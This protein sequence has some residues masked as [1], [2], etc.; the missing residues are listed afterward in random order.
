MAEDPRFTIPMQIMAGSNIGFTANFFTLIRHCPND[1][2]YI[3]FCDQDDF[4]LPEKIERAVAHFKVQDRPIP[5]PTLYFSR[6]AIADADLKVAGESPVHLKVGLGQAI[7]E[8]PATG[9]TICINQEALVLLKEL[10]IEPKDVV[11]HDWWIYLVVCCFGRILYDPKVT[12]LY[13][14]HGANSLG[15]TSSPVKA[16]Q[17]RMNGL[18]SGRWKQRRPD[19]MIAWMLRNLP[20]GGITDEK[21]Q[22]LVV[23]G[24]RLRGF[25]AALRLWNTGQIWRRGLVNQMM[26]PWLLLMVPKYKGTSITGP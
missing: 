9:C 21:V 22:L 17:I 19:N 8:N 24:L 2:D 6:L 1:C 5:D 26:V 18:L 13:R 16:L 11:A 10:S 14:Q 23:G 25:K 12:I 15:A 3:F 4:W 7:F 20:E